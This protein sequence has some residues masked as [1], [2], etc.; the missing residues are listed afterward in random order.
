MPREI[1]IRCEG[2]SRKFCRDLKRSLWYGVQDIAAD[3]IR[4][5]HKEASGH[6][7]RDGEFWAN[8]DISFEVR[9]GE[10]LGLVGRN[11]AGK[12]TLLKMLNGL[13]KP[14]HGRIELHGRIGALIALGAGFNPIL[15]GRENVFVNGSI[16][17]LTQRQVS[18]RFDEIVAFAELEEFIDTPVQ[19][20]S[21]GMKVRLGFAVATT[22]R[23][24]ILLIDEV[25]A[26][27]DAAFRVRCAQRIREVM[28]SGCAVVLVSHDMTQ[29][30]NLCTQAL[31][32]DRGQVHQVGDPKTVVREYLAPS[33]EKD[34]PSE[35]VRLS[36]T[37]DKGTPAELMRIKVISPHGQDRISISSG[38]SVLVEF[39]TRQNGLHLDFTFDLI[40]DE[41]V[42]VFHTGGILNESAGSRIGCYQIEV[43]LPGY[44]LNSGRYSLSVWLGESQSTI[45]SRVDHAVNFEVHHEPAGV[46]F[47]KLPGVIAPKLDWELSITERRQTDGT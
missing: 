24:R 18:E 17:G 36:N 7:L 44:L 34:N 4:L 6:D 28:D 25:L 27:G 23:P 13:I 29:I 22:I 38:G 8:R 45:L 21:S 33:A 20:Y 16:L 46:N 2:V 12:T 39:D 40:N 37:S 5:G 32:L 43:A 19:N 1:L 3:F 30:C 9:S 47:S 14:D 11:G 26:V 35:W 15:T 31:W 10:C 41:G 42:Q